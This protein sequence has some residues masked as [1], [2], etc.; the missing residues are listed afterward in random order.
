MHTLKNYVIFQREVPNDISKGS[1]YFK[2]VVDFSNNKSAYW[3]N[4]DYVEKIISSNE[5]TSYKY[6]CGKPE[7]GHP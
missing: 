1:E 6:V 5:T 7:Q 4:Q 2:K 3:K